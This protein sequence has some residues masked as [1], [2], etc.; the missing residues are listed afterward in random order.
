[1]Q[2]L[3]LLA[4]V[5]SIASGIFAVVY[6]IASGILAVV[7]SIASGIMLVI[8]LLLLSIVIIVIID[9]SINYIFDDEIKFFENYSVESVILVAM[10]LYIMS[11]V[12]INNNNNDIKK[13]LVNKEYNSV[14]SRKSIDAVFLPLK[15]KTTIDSPLNENKVN[16]MSSY[17][18]ENIIALP[19]KLSIEDIVND[20]HLKRLN[21]KFSPN[22]YLAFKN[23]KDLRFY[24]SA[25]YAQGESFE[26]EIF[27]VKQQSGI[28]NKLLYTK[29]IYPEVQRITQDLVDFYLIPRITSK[30]SF[31][32]EI[33]KPQLPSQP[34]LVKSEYETK[35]TFQARV[36]EKVGA[37]EQQIQSL[38]E[39]YR[40][41]VEQRNQEVE[42]IASKYSED[43]KAIKAEQTY[44]KSVLPEKIKAFQRGAF[45]MVMG[46]FTFSKRSYDA[47]TEIMYVTMKSSRANYHKKISINIPINEAKSFSDNI[48]RV[49]ALP[50]F[51]FKNNEI[52]L[53]SINAKAE[54]E[55]YAAVLN[56]TDFKPERIEVAITDK[57][58]KFENIE[59]IHLSLQ[60]PNLSDSYQVELSAYKDGKHVIGDT[61][62]DDIP[63][64][65]N[66]VKQATINNTKWLFIIGIEKYDETDDIKFS[67]RSAIAFKDVAK[68]TLGIKERNIVT[69]L[70]NKATAGRIKNQLRIFLSEIKQGDTLYF[71]YNGHGIPD[72]TNEGEP[73]ILP[74]DMVPDFIVS[75]QGFA[76]KNIYQQL[77]NSKAG[78][79]VAFIDSCFSGSTDGRAVIKGV[80]ASRLIPKQVGFDKDKMVILTAGQKMQYSN[81]YKEKGHRMFSYFVM[82]SLLEGKRDVSL[83]FKEISY[84][85]SEASNELGSLKKQ[86]PTLDGNN[87]IEL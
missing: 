71:Y 1:M 74:S 17:L 41:D 8:I 67:K 37:R 85:V 80:A 26:D 7:Y 22:G 49:K 54:K 20:D 70:D 38:Q 23:F 53:K 10:S 6:S 65:L 55:I 40:K 68:K 43:I 18:K 64:L 15:E 48:N 81:M 44:K 51:D 30:P 5:Y 62:K 36:N 47:E 77:S 66:K 72:P 13:P 50:L 76:L 27:T 73:Y 14:I 28:L 12:I 69:L 87:E 32:K 31:P 42:Q 58:V 56:D 59:Q 2:Y 35:I 78:K 46:Q 24:I 9:T 3:I 63:K 83:L 16:L 29:N 60:N 57:A 86:E 21:A 25:I 19:L 11:N 45:K 33:Q 4:V 52:T 34:T 82:K 84:K 75:E 79:V 39:Q 61:Y